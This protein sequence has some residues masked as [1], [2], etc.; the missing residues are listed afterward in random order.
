MMIL[1][2]ILLYPSSGLCA[3][4]DAAYEQLPQGSGAPGNAAS[5]LELQ[6]APSKP[7]IL[8]VLDGSTR[9]VLFHHHLVVGEVSAPEMLLHQ[10]DDEVTTR[11]VE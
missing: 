8:L 9:T 5:H 1:R 7:L 3:M 6:R 11:W 4:P 2:I 10:R